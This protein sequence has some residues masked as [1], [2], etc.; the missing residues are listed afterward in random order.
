MNVDWDAYFDPGSHHLFVEGPTTPGYVG[1]SLA[2]AIM[3]RTAAFLEHNSAP[4][5]VLGDRA[6]AF[7]RGGCGRC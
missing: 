6:G 4:R 3:S 1:D 5:S 2:E 7:G